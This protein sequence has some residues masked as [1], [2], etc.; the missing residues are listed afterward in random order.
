MTRSALTARVGDPPRPVVTACV[1]KFLRGF[2]SCCPRRVDL[3]CGEF[4]VLVCASANR[5]SRYCRRP[6]GAE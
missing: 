1:G 3:C 6:S 2:A 5:P 4:G